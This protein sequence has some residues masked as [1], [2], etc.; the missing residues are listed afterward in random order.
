MKNPSLLLLFILFLYTLN[1]SIAAAAYTAPYSQ[2]CITTYGTYGGPFGTY[3]GSGTY[4]GYTQTCTPVDTTANSSSMIIAPIVMRA[5][6]SQTAD[7]ISNRLAR[8]AASSGVAQRASFGGGEQHTLLDKGD[9]LTTVGKWSIWST[10]ARK[11]LSDDFLLTRSDGFIDT[12]AVGGDYRISTDII[13]GISV[14]YESSDID[15]AFNQ[16]SYRSRGVSLA[17]YGLLRLNERVSIDAALGYGQFGIKTKRNFGLASGSTDSDRW[18]GLINLN[19]NY[20][21]QQWRLG[22]K[23]GY[24][25][26]IE[27]QDSFTES[28]GTTYTGQDIYLGQ[29]RVGGRIGYQFKIVQP[30]I[31]VRYEHDNVQTSI[32]ANIG[33]SNDQ[34]GLNTAIG[35]DFAP[36]TGGVQGGFSM[37]KE[38][39][40][41]QFDS[42]AIHG[43]IRIPLN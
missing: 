11:R 27:K 29:F 36:T 15:T 39:G 19:Y 18:L 3:G 43:H 7:I 13:S 33:Y 38:F 20:P 4:G 8:Y 12:F 25:Y 37:Q 16:G 5:A 2:T 26:S 32:P 21:V 28:D 9:A 35:M 24:L 22:A 30:Y 40:R 1:P 14:L 17:P 42:M 34:N 41:S 31:R 6:V 10:I 23:A